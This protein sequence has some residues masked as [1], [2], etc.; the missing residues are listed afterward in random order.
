MNHEFNNRIRPYSKRELAMMYFPETEN[1]ETAVKNFRRLLLSHRKLLADLY[2]ICY[3]TRSKRFT[4][5]QVELIFHY[6]GEP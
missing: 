3:V 1:E 2:D 6:L 5:R 4:S